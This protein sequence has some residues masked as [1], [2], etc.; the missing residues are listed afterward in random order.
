MWLRGRSEMVFTL[1][2]HELMSS[3]YQ[4]LPY[5]CSLSLFCILYTDCLPVWFVSVFC[6]LVSRTCMVNCQWMCYN[7]VLCP[8][9]Y[10]IDNVPIIGS[11]PYTLW[12]IV[13]IV[14]GLYIARGL[15]LDCHILWS[16]S[17]SCGIFIFLK[18]LVLFMK[19]LF[20]VAPP[21]SRNVPISLCNNLLWLRWKLYLVIIVFVWPH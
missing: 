19:C 16:L 1:S 3:F 12:V 20:K 17:T 21:P 15:S 5:S 14:P 2:W 9:L 8:L 7:S 11:V 10:V 18:T 13:G 6:R 4:L